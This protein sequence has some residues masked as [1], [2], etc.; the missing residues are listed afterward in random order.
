MKMALLM[1]E[2]EFNST[3]NF[4]S[5]E[6]VTNACRLLNRGFTVFSLNG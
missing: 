6:T 3:G 1:S 2:N 5:T 4:N